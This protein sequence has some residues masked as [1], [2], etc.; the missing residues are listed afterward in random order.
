VNFLEIVPN[1]DF[2]LKANAL[3]TGENCG[4]K[5]RRDSQL[6]LVQLINLLYAST[7]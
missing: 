4:L 5:S 6:F 7:N 2:L 3:I 1:V